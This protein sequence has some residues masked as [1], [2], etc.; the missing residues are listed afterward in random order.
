MFM[1]E[2]G[3]TASLCKNYNAIKFFLPYVH[4]AWLKGSD[5]PQML[6]IG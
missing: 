6:L 2:N 4:Y 1:I 5:W 3:I